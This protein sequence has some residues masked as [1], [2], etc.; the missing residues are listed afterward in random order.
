MQQ[1]WRIGLLV[2][3]ITLIWG[4]AWVWMKVGLSYM[5][6]FTF[7]AFRFGIGFFTLFVIIAFR[8]SR[9]PKREHLPGFLIVGILQ[10]TLVFLLVMYGMHFVEAGKSSV[11]LYSMPIWSSLLASKF[12][13]E[14]LNV[15]K[16]I[17]VLSGGAG[18]CFIMGW[19][20]WVRQDSSIIL[21]ESL[22]LLA[23]LSWACANIVVKKKLAHVNKLQVS[24]Y[25][26]G[27]GTIGILLAT[28]VMEWGEPV[29]LNATSCFAI[30]FTGVLAS[31]LCFTIWFYVL[32]VI[33][34]TTATISTMLVP[35][36]GVF[37][38]W[39]ALNE[40]ITIQ[41][42]IGTLLILAGIFTS[43]HKTGE[44]RHLAKDGA[45]DQRVMY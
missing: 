44:K 12:L 1:R 19:D 15:R 23:S 33:D 38:S 35:I 6:P 4:Y 27:F 25:Q 28:C 18:L 41:M 17:G 22:I 5:G 31:A 29:V 32:S 30:L 39:L 11:L 13:G 3:L 2:L 26:M 8:K 42:A 20:V 16:V 43:Q 7:S 21:G 24:T 9:L 45:A 10:T 40:P 36:F 37:F 14:R 34:T